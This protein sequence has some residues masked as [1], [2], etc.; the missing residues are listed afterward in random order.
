MIQRA[1][2]TYSDSPAAYAI[3]AKG[4]YGRMRDTWERLIEELLFAG[5][6][7]RFQKSVSSLRLKYLTAHPRV[8][9]R[10]EA[11]MT[12]TSTFS[13]DNA[14]GSS[15][16]VPDPAEMKADLDELSALAELLRKHQRAID[17]GKPSPIDGGG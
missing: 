1:A 8:M 17:D 15:D 13:H 2:K 16:H 14:P 9:R 6:V 5:V 10:I 12:K 4:I 11:G 7:Q 3:E